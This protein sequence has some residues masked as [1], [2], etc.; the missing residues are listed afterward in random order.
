MHYKRPNLVFFGCILR[1]GVRG[2][3]FIGANIG[4]K[5]DY[6]MFKGSNTEGSS[7]TNF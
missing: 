7:F 3:C 2:R 5:L 4:I 1:L 6:K